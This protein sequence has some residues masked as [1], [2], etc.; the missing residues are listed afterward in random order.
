MR[1]T[2]LAARSA[3][4]GLLVAAGNGRGVTVID[5]DGL[6]MATVTARKGALEPLSGRIRQHFG[7]ELPGGPTLVSAGGVSFAGTAPAA[8]LAM[9]ERGG[10]EFPAALR[11]LVGASAAV[12]DQSDGYGVLRLTGP[13]VRSALAKLVPIDIHPRAFKPGAVAATLAA[14]MG[15]ILWRLED[16]GVVP[17]FE[18]AV[19]RSLAASFWHALAE[20]AAEFGLAVGRAE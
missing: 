11:Q 16:A 18:I 7:L 6:G 15:L 1:D 13:E 8:W 4:S 9:R 3:F 14:H 5:R 19:F 17:V 2:A 20:S 10:N 12:T